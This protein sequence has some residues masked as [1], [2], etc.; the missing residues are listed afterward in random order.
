MADALSRNYQALKPHERFALTLEAIYHPADKV[1]F[2]GAIQDDFQWVD[3]RTFVWPREDEQGSFIEWRVYDVTTGKERA[4]FERAKFVTALT[5]LGVDDETAYVVL[6]YAMGINAGVISNEV[7]P[8]GGVKQSG[9]GREGSS[10]GIEEYL[11]IKYLAMAG[12]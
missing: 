6:G 11:E 12:L 2:A 1:A 3:D 7:A 5:A 10:H 4:L 8:F 9:L